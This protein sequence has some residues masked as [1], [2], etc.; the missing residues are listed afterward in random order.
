M[1]LKW[2]WPGDKF[3]KCWRYIGP[4]SRLGLRRQSHPCAIVHR[5]CG[6]RW[7]QDGLLFCVFWC[8]IPISSASINRF[9]ELQFWGGWQRRAVGCRLSAN[10]QGTCSTGNNPTTVPRVWCEFRGGEK[11]R[12][13]SRTS[14]RNLILL[15][16]ARRDRGRV[17]FASLRVHASAAMSGAVGTVW[18]DWSAGGCARRCT[19]R[20]LV[21]MAAWAQDTSELSR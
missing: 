8:V 5:I 21:C 1:S 14:P 20:N 9:F 12:A 13:R 4:R 6:W 17:G 18:G 16:V 15:E 3:I 2:W 19:P 10:V 11:R 7:V